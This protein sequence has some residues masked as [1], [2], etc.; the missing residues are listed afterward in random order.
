MGGPGREVVVDYMKLHLRNKK[1][2]KNDE[3]LIVGFMERENSIT[4]GGR[5]RGYIVP[6]IKIQTIA[7]YMA[8]VIANKSVVYTPFYQET[9]WE[10]LDKFFEHKRLTKTKGKVP[11]YWQE[12]EK[13]IQ[14]SGFANMW[15]NIKAID[16]NFMRYA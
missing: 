7:Q 1:T 6:N 3:W 16:I 10:F 13:W 14:L 15:R 8:K 5:C 11:D 9:G 12:K 4:S 2:N